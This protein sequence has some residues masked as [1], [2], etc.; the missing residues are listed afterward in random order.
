MRKAVV[1]GLMLVALAGLARADEACGEGRMQDGGCIKEDSFA[2]GP[3]INLAFVTRWKAADVITF[4][5]IDVLESAQLVQTLE[6]PDMSAPMLELSAQDANFDG[7]SDLM[8]LA[9]AGA[10]GNT[11][12]ML[13]LFDPETRRFVAFPRFL[14]LSSP[15]FDPVNKQ[16]NTH[17]KGGHAGL[18]YVDMSYKWNGLSIYKVAEE[19]Q[20][21]MKMPGYFYNVRYKGKGLIESEKIVRVSDDGAETVVYGPTSPPATCGPVIAVIDFTA[22]ELQRDVEA[23]MTFYAPLV[24]WQG[25]PKSPEALKAMHEKWLSSLVEYKLSVDNFRVALSEDGQTSL[26]VADVTGIY[27]DQS[28]KGHQFKTAKQF[29]LSLVDGKWKIGCEEVSAFLDGTRAKTSN[30]CRL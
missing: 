5:T 30:E 29:R 9:A 11:S 20:D 18:L 19:R 13:W 25:A 6:M 15:S 7:F 16:I 28:G 23:M 2:I 3:G 8:L 24:V 22:A 21:E 12:Y 1:F 4:V 26:V 14:D 17:N 27:T 10:T